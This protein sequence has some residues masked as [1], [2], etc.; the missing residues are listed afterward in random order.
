MIL[1]IMKKIIIVFLNLP[2]VQAIKVLN[3]NALHLKAIMAQFSVRES[4]LLK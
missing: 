3:H 2:V 4:L 1:V